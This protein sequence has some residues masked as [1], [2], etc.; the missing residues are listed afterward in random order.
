[1]HRDY[2]IAENDIASASGAY[3]STNQGRQTDP[4]KSILRHFISWQIL[5][6]FRYT[7]IDFN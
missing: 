6:P 7:V 5:P 1:M 3:I 2:Q 4:V